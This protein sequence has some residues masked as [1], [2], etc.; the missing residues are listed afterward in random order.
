MLKLELEEHVIKSLDWGDR[1]ELDGT[2]LRLNQADLEQR[3]ADLCHGIAV[4]FE[5]ARPGES[6]RIVHVL[7]TVL[8]IAKLDGP[9]VTF[10]G[11]EEP[12]TLAG[13]GRT[14]RIDNLLVTV[15][16]HFPHAE[17]LSPIETP[18]LPSSIT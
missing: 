7:D 18:R 2:A 8:P 11:F 9:G 6:K 14:V 16:G 13:T 3:I 10:P 4:K 1:T 5:L 12:P 17:L 15:T